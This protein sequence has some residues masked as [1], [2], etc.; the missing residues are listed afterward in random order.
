MRGGDEDN[1]RT[2]R[3]WKIGDIAGNAVTFPSM[4][5]FHQKTND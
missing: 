5:F 4:Y 1:G 2:R 3:T